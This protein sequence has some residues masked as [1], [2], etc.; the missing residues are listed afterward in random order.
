MCAFTV[1]F[2]IIGNVLAQEKASDK[3]VVEKVA[4][5]VEEIVIISTRSRRS[6]AQ[7]PT[8]V[9]VLGA[10][11]INEK[12][13]MKPGSIR[14]LLNESTGIYVQQT[15]A[16]SF[17]SSIRI[18][19]L[20]GKYTQ[21]LR[22]GMP[23]YGGF[24][25]GL[26]LL[27]IAPLDLQQVELIKGASSTLFGGGAIAGLVNLI[28]KTPGSES[29]R[30]LLLNG[31]SAGG[32]D[33]SG[34]F[35]GM[36]K[37]GL[38]ATLFTSINRSEAYDPADNG[39][40]AIPE[41]ERATFSPRVF[42][43]SENSELSFGVSAVV[44]DRLGGSMDYIEGNR[45]QP[46]YFENSETTRL[47][48]QFQYN[49]HLASGDEL[50]LRNSVNYFDRDLQIPDF[51]FSGTQVSSFSEA[52]I[53]REVGTGE[54]IAGLNLWTDDFDQ[55]GELQAFSHD[56]ISRTFGAFIQG[57][58][59]LGESLI[60]ESGLRVDHTSNYGSF[61]LPRISLLFTPSS[62]TTVRVGGGLG[63][64]EPT[65]FTEAAEMLQFRGVLPLDLDNLEAEQSAGVNVDINRSFQ[66]TNDLS[67]NINFLFF[68]TRV[69]DPLS[70]VP[71][72]ESRFVYRQI[73]DYL[74]TSGTE[75]N[76]VW[77]WQDLKLFL[78]YTNA[79]VVE[80][81]QG[82]DFDSPLI[83]QER[84]NSVLVY[85]REDDLRIGLEAYYFSSQ[86]LTDGSRGRDYW[87]FGLMM[88]KIFSD[89]FSFFLNFEN[90]TDTRQ[91]RYDPLFT[92]SLANPIFN[93]IYAPLDGFVVNGGVKLKF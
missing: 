31:T 25:G 18:Q 93:D 29:E 9:E 70:L 44:E 7:Q 24:S 65:P 67:F 40:S 48:T 13:N 15:S 38:G 90:F 81:R 10:E 37:D 72:G 33:A 68:Y 1:S 3:V 82:T 51:N 62:N 66:L 2:S 4:E 27:Q 47:A 20:D 34:F 23:L 6:F 61:V 53:L 86:K 69:D 35:S 73:N 87:I 91:T 16:T 32:L 74:D 79:D 84:V 77:R 22:D 92:G 14:M 78:G 5:K 71:E 43:E 89:D 46:A 28:S 85:E 88:E 60:L 50:V 63:Y 56:F 49:Y 64:K 45:N 11:E 36:N 21:L 19:G 41:F 39:I 76:A 55:A 42:V 57:T 75:I 12:V 52:H 54:W 58:I 8:R 83:P 59:P 80:H 17:N 30:S 26:S